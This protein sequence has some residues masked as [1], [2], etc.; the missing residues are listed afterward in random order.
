[1]IETERL[2]LRPWREEDR[3]AWRE[4]MADPE[5]GYW[6]GGV[7]TPTESDA[8]FDRAK[9]AIEADGFG[10]WAAER[11]RDGAVIGAVGVRGVIGADHPMAGTTELGWRLARHAWGDGYATE[12]AAASL[13]WGFAN[14]AVAELVAFTAAANVRSAAV[15]TRIGMTRAPGRDF[16]HP[17]L[18]ESH[19]LRRH[20]V[21]VARR[22]AP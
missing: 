9:A 11:K 6:L 20:V 12:G 16:D 13:A 4:M 3:P 14:L 21:Y 10:M 19:P 1:M 17:A 5:V 18:A 2:V 8:A 15:M 7:M 22:G